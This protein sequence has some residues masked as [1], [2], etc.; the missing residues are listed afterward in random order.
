[1][2]LP[3]NPRP[4]ADAG[5]QCQR[6][7]I[8]Q[9]PHPE[10]VAGPQQSHHTSGAERTKPTGLVIRG[11][12]RELEGVPLFV[13]HA[14]V[15][16]GHDTEAVCAR[17][18]VRV[19]NVSLVDDLPPVVVL[20]LQPVLE[21][22]LLRRDEAERR[23]VDLQIA[24]ARRES[25]AGHGHIAGHVLPPD[26]VIGDQPLDMHRCSDGV[27]RK[28]PR[29][30][31]LDALSHDEPQLAIRRPGR[32]RTI[33]GGRRRPRV[34]RH[35]P[36]PRASSGCNVPGGRTT[37]PAR[38]GRCET[39]RRRRTPTMSRSRPVSSGESCRRADRHGRQRGDTAV[40]DPAEAALLRGRPE[41]PITIELDSGNV[42][43]PQPVGHAVRGADP[44]VLEIRD[45]PITP[46]RQPHSVLA[47]ADRAPGTG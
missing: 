44:T 35:R 18:E 6:E 33:G 23:V 19:L 36:H 10:Q 41:R 9:S 47:T 34:S 13:P 30:D 4:L 3:R 8:V 21:A 37:R 31:D 12:H 28:V 40:L 39:G 16:A 29:V 17:R 42:A 43:L 2:Q 46:E 1:V 45:A 38:S 32:M 25:N 22:D 5:V 14:A 7:L 15:V 24:H 26:I 20:A 11:G 27:G